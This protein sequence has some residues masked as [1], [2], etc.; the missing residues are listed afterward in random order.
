MQKLKAE[1]EAYAVYQTAARLKGKRACDLA[2]AD[3]SHPPVINELDL[4]GYTG[5]PAEAIHIQAIDDFEV[6]SVRV[7]IAQLDGALL[8]DGAAVLDR[9]S[10]SWRYLTQVAVPAG[11]TLMVH[12]TASDQAG[13]EV[14][15]TFHHALVAAP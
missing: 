7:T 12:I 3:C 2:K 15:K 10:G 13:N 4:S 1:P 5:Q 9:T 14:T 11:Q 6:R 8:E